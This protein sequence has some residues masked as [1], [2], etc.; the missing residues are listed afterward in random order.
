[1]GRPVPHGAGTQPQGVLLLPD[2][3]GV[4]GRPVVCEDVSTSSLCLGMR[5]GQL[6]PSVRSLNTSARPSS[7][8]HACPTNACP[9]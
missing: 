2:W 1:M 9:F 5:D 8:G 3:L 7:T 6:L 4:D